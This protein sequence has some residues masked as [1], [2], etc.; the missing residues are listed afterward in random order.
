MYII[1]II[2]NC[3]WIVSVNSYTA[4]HSA[5]KIRCACSQ[6][7]RPWEKKAVFKKQEHA[8]RPSARSNERGMGESWFHWDGPIKDK[9]CDFVIAV[10]ASGTKSSSRSSEHRGQSDVAEVIT[11]NSKGTFPR[12]S[13]S[14]CWSRERLWVV[15]SRD[16]IQ[17]FE[18][19]NEWGVSLLIAGAIPPT[20]AGPGTFPDTAAACAAIA[21]SDVAA[22]CW[23]WRWHCLRSNTCSQKQTITSMPSKP[24]MHI[25]YSSLSPNN[26]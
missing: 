13:H 17:I 26:L 2:I 23:I 16:A 20:L 19:M 10:P 25:A 7:E 12:V 1:D 24:M 22:C 3:H 5:T 15:S 21:A 8:E 11:T 6:C 9:A 4:H 18:W 14:P